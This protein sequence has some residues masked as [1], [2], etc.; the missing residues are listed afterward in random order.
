[1]D[2]GLEIWNFAITDSNDSL[3]IIH[4]KF[5]TFTLGVSTNAANLE[6][7]GKLRHT[8]PSVCRKVQMVKYCYGL[9]NENEDLPIYLR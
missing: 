4:H 8:T 9:S 7:N 1:M 2:Y 5:C 3:E 6:V